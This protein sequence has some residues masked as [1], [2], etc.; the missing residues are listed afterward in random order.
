MCVCVC[1]CMLWVIFVDKQNFRKNTIA[2]IIKD[3]KSYTHVFRVSSFNL[4]NSWDALLVFVSVY[5]HSTAQK[6]IHSILQQQTLQ[7]TQFSYFMKCKIRFV[8]LSKCVGIMYN[9]AQSWFKLYNWTRRPFMKHFI[10][11]DA[12]DSPYW[13]L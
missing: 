11:S 6:L 2:C 5:R 7:M 8:C 3:V 1:F 4:L 12:T 10:I 9:T 13:P